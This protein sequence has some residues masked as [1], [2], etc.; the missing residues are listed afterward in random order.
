MLG[1][2]ENSNPKTRNSDLPKDRWLRKG[3]KLFK[4]ITET[5]DDLGGRLEVE[6]KK[7]VQVVSDESETVVTELVSLSVLLKLVLLI[8]AT[9]LIFH[10]IRLTFVACRYLFRHIYRRYRGISTSEEVDPEL[11]KF[12]LTVPVLITNSAGHSPLVELAANHRWNVCFDKK[13]NDFVCSLLPLAE[14]AESDT[15]ICESYAPSLGGKSKSSIVWSFSL[16]LHYN[17]CFKPELPALSPTLNSHLTNKSKYVV[18]DIPTRSYRLSVALV[19][20]KIL[21]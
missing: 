2:N 14:R 5:A 16:C 8:L 7:L 13:S 18:K 12:V 9:L 10:I 17:E 15:S 4:P 20:V 3:Q 6:V 21:V 19:L 1:N 11:P